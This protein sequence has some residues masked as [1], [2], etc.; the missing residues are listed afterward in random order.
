M[1]NYASNSIRSKKEVEHDR[2][3][4]IEK[5]VKN[6]VVIRKKSGFSKFFS[7]FIN[8]DMKSVKEYLLS[9]VLL[10]AVKSTLSDA[11]SNGT[12]MLLYGE[13]RGKRSSGYSGPKVS[14]NSIYNKDPRNKTTSSLDTSKYK[15]NRISLDDIVLRTRAEAEDILAQMDD[16][17]SEYGVVSVLDLYDM[18]GISTQFVDDNYGWID[19][20][21]GASVVRVSDGYELRLPK[22]VPIR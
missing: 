2:E 7:D 17:M 13:T 16:V 10:P 11:I 12:D 6:D 1:E 8:G 20:I 19:N 18:L 5:V 22:V 21:S 15:S 9:D 14:Y 4:K 3:K